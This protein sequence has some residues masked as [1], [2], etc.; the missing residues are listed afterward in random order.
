MEWRVQ[1]QAQRSGWDPVVA[2]GRDETQIQ[3]SSMAADVKHCTLTSTNHELRNLGI[4][5]PNLLF[6]YISGDKSE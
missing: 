1:G 3:N 6:R 4:S 2:H 5:E